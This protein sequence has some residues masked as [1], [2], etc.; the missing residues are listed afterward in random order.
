VLQ[1]SDDDR[2]GILCDGRPSDPRKRHPDDPITHDPRAGRDPHELDAAACACFIQLLRQACVVELEVAQLARL[3]IEPERPRHVRQ[4]AIARRR[5]RQSHQPGRFSASCLRFEAMRAQEWIAQEHVRI[6]RLVRPCSIVFH[7]HVAPRNEVTGGGTAE[8][9]LLKPR[10]DP[11]GIL[12]AAFPSGIEL[13]VEVADLVPVRGR[14]RGPG[15]GRECLPHFFPQCR[16]RG[17]CLDVALA[18]AG[19]HDLS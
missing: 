2:Y 7:D 13:A 8:R 16:D 14:A 19:H 15:D 17:A 10:L 18:L 4:R 9:N 6:R 12:D 1:K 3:L 11:G 5:E